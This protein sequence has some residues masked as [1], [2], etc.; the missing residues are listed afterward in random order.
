MKT[1]IIYGILGVILLSSCSKNKD[2]EPIL[3][4]QSEQSALSIKI[5]NQAY[6][7]SADIYSTQIETNAQGTVYS[8]TFNVKTNTP[9]GSVQFNVE[10]LK[11]SSLELGS[12]PMNS[13][14][15]KTD[16]TYHSNNQKWSSSNG[17]QKGSV[18]QVLSSTNLKAAS[19]YVTE[20]KVQVSCYLYN[21]DGESIPF[22]CITTIKF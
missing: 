16:I 22:S 11:G 13:K 5:N 14:G 3:S 6:Q 2:I 19:G 15:S 21:T 17:H 1:L 8:S 20:I 10:S 4:E 9:N 12:Y 18:F 7:K